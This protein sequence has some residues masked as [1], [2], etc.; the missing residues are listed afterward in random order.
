VKPTTPVLQMTMD[1][2]D[3]VPLG[4]ELTQ[5]QM[6]VTGNIRAV[7]QPRFLARADIFVLKMIQDAKGRSVFFSRTSGGY[8]FELGLG[9]YVVTQGLARKLLPDSVVGDSNKTLVKLQG[10][11]WMDVAR[12][13]A[14][15]AAFRSPIA[16]EKKNKWIDKASVGIPYLYVN[17]NYFLAE[18]LG[19]QGDKAGSDKALDAAMRVAKATGLGDLFS[20]ASSAPPAPPPVSAGDSARRTKVPVKP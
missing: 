2:A 6:F 9:S 10:E 14:L 12:T 7:I 18:A 19:Q 11:G 5:P 8:P 16:L 1:E 4:Q 13:K 17:T 20:G 15:A 3:A